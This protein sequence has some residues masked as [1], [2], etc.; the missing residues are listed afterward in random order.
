LTTDF[1]RPWKPE[2]RLLTTILHVQLPSVKTNYVDRAINLSYA[3]AMQD[4]TVED[5][6]S[7]LAASKIP[8]WKLGSLACGNVRAIERIFAGTAAHSTVRAVQQYMERNPVAEK[9]KAIRK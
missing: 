2:A 8:P 4:Q 3:P 5:I 9:K 1:L 7:Y 6:R